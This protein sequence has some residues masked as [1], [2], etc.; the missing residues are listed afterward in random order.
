MK[1]RVL[2]ALNAET[3]WVLAELGFEILILFEHETQNQI[4]EE[5]GK[6]QVPSGSFASAGGWRELS[7][8]FIIL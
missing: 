8:V 4:H 7:T 2:F 5:Q 1:S 3:R 6:N